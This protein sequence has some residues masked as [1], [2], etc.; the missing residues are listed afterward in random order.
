M[1]RIDLYFVIFLIAIFDRSKKRLRRNGKHLRRSGLRVSR[2][3]RI[4]DNVSP[5]SRSVE[6]LSGKLE[7]TLKTIKK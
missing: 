7:E 4:C 3:L 1:C 6:R 5:R 2:K